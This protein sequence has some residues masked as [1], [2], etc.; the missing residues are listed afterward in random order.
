MKTIILYIIL[1]IPAYSVM[2]DEIKCKYIEY[3]NASGCGGGTKEI[4]TDG[5]TQW[6]TGNQTAWAVNCPI[7]FN[8]ELY[9]PKLWEE[10][11]PL[12][13]KELKVEKSKENKK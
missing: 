8:K 10:E 1:S 3:H 13:K 2:A 12:A 4:C 11:K 5:K 6:E 9:N 7:E